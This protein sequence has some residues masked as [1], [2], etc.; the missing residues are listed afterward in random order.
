MSTSEDRR[1]RFKEIVVARRATLLPGAANALAARIAEDLGYEAVYLTGAGV[2]NTNLGM[3]DLGLIT[4]LELA[5]AAARIGDVC[6]LPLAVDIDTG[7]GNA[8]NAYR[9]MQVMERAGAAAVQIEDQIFPKKC[10][11][12]SGKDVVP[13][14]EILGKI[15]ACLD[16][17]VDPNLQV[18]A[19]TDARAVLGFEAAM[20][21]AEAFAEVGA[22]II[23]VEAPRSADE[24]RRIGALPSPQVINIVIGGLTPMLPLPE[25][26]DA[27]FSLVLY[28]NAALQASIRAIGNI[29]GHLK[30][31]GTLEGAEDQLA[32][33][34]ER[35][36]VVRKDWYDALE[37][38]YKSS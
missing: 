9:T 3:P 35:Q 23:F 25:L 27:G 17:R 24:I 11:H 16:A 31:N 10:G 7:F 20:E 14:D 21:R 19:R 22:D 33:F 37:A 13:L 8:L 6:A 36:Q 38:S 5:E 29:L 15:K 28:A 4:P 1:R 26:R 34:D 18:I 2:T 12:F 32:G 30:D